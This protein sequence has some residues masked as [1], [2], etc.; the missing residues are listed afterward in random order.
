V[1]VPNRRLGPGSQ[2]GTTRL[3]KPQSLDVREWFTVSSLLFFAIIAV[4]WYAV[5]Q[6]PAP[7]FVELAK[8]YQAAF[9]AG[10]A[11][12]SWRFVC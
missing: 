6:S 2:D 9:N 1:D 4:P 10:D 3:Y 12:K 11:A 8:Q 5:A 7:E